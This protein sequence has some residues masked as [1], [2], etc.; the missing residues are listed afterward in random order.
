MM[1]QM[2]ATRAPDQAAGLR[3]MM[4]R[5]TARLVAVVEQRVPQRTGVA[6]GL[7]RALAHQHRGVLMMDE[8]QAGAATHFS[9]G[10]AQAT[11]LDGARAFVSLG[12]VLAGFVPQADFVIVDTVAENEGLSRLASSAHDVVIVMRGNDASG[13]TLTATY[14]CIKQLHSQ[15]ALMHF[16]ILV[17]DCTSEASAYGMYCRLAAVASRYLTVVLHFCGY[18]PGASAAGVSGPAA[19]TSDASASAGGASVVPRVRQQTAYL[20]VSRSMLLWGR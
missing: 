17:T 12:E 1:E 16:R 13:A 20:N 11:P 9:P 5:R 10:A 6:A 3:S 2:L 7:A 15:H 14:A 4:A 19:V 18:V 8:N